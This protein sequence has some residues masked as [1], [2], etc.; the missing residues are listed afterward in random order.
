MDVIE[1]TIGHYKTT[2][3]ELQ[4]CAQCSLK[5]VVIAHGVHKIS[6]FEFQAEK[7]GL[8]PDVVDHFN[9]TY[10]YLDNISS[11]ERKIKYD[12]SLGLEKICDLIEKEGKFIEKLRIVT[13]QLCWWFDLLSVLTEDEF[14]ERSEEFIM[15]MR[16]T[17]ARLCLVTG[18][19][20]VGN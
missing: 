7:I 3:K 20:R 10:D 15:K 14:K 1:K 17:I 6:P 18:E 4:L 13:I 2:L 8:T 19:M 11:L 9:K 5:R 12:P 16:T